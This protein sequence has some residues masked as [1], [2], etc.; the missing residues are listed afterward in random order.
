MGQWSARPEPGSRG[1]DQPRVGFA[2]RLVTQTKTLG[3]AGAKVVN[4]HVRAI[5]QLHHDLEAGVLADIK[6]HSPLVAV[7]AHEIGTFT[8]RLDYE[9]IGRAADIAVTGAL[10]LDN[11][12]PEVAE[13]LSGAGTEL[14]LRQIKDMNAVERK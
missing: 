10:D 3:D 4:Q 6:S 9:R 14:H 7:E 8:A 2:Q 12:R 13:H 1:I 5:Q 11:M